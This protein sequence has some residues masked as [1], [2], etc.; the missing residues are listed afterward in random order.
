MKHKTH[1]RNQT[2][3]STGL[4]SEYHVLSLL[5]RKGIHAH[6]TLGNYKEVDIVVISRNGDAKTIDVKGASWIDFRVNN[7]GKPRRNHYF[8]FVAYD[9][10]F[11]DTRHF[12]DV[13]IVPSAKLHKLLHEYHSGSNVRL[14][15]LKNALCAFEDNWRQLK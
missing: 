11:S 9:K 5:H 3:Q 1:Q 14:K 6:L 15:D 12:P 4:A 8:I 2:H 7:I 13:Y 10:L